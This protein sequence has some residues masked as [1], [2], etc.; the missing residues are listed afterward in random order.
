M[1]VEL[2]P[3]AL[4]K[5]NRAQDHFERVRREVDTF[6]HPKAYRV[7][8]EPNADSTEYRFYI[9]FIDPLPSRRW[10]LIV[11]DGVHCLR[12]ALDHCVYAIGVRESGTD[13][14][15]GERALVFPITSN[16]TR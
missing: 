11:G 14:P 8:P 3:S 6:F 16:S 15:P 10:G 5:F 7:R 13:P 12:S 2:L 4:E 1:A 9:E